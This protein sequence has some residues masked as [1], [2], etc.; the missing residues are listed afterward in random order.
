MNLTHKILD[1]SKLIKA[2]LVP[3][4]S[5]FIVS[6]EDFVEVDA[7]ETSLIGESVFND[8]I[9]ANAAVAGI[10]SDMVGSAGT[11][12]TNTENLHNLTGIAADELVTFSSSEDEVQ[13][14]S[15]ELFPGNPNMSFLWNECYK[16]IYSCNSIIEGVSGSTG[17]TDSLANQ[18]EGEARF[19][20]AWMYFNLVNFWGD[21]P[22]AITSDFQVNASLSRSSV[23]IVYDQIVDDLETAR[24]LLSEEYLTFE[25]VRPNRAVATA[26]LARVH[27]YRENWP[28]AESLAS[29]LIDDG[30]YVLEPDLN[31][32]FSISSNE[33]LWQ[34]Q[35]VVPGVGTYEGVRFIL[36][37]SPAF[38]GGVSLREDFV[39]SFE[40]GDNRA[41]QWI[42]TYTFFDGSTFD[43]PFKYQE[44]LFSSINVLPTQYSTVIRLAE[45]YL[46]RAEA[47]AQ[48]NNVT[49]AQDDLNAIRSRAGLPNTS[50]SDR[51]NLLLAVEQERK[52]ELF[53]EYGHRWFDLNRTNRATAVLS[54]L[55]EGWQETDALWPVPQLEFQRNPN[56]GDQNPGY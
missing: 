18:Y 13:I 46:I 55:K 6:C 34:L 5:V 30:R 22:L 25:R 4:L 8:D 45:M 29:A 32:V 48:Q 56:L 21:V 12:F 44:S 36:T 16:Y 53:T 19:V 17:I 47:R 54:P 31:D 40:A 33:A 35:S 43:Y 50:A 7:P 2:S 1:R 14:A 20:R 24:E 52:F 15:N 49:G 51:S 28:E 39:N 10:Y 37:F 9:N 38:T 23:D 3:I 42:D 41:T 27:L 26:L 11:V